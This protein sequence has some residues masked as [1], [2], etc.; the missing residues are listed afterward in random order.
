MHQYWKQNRR[1]ILMTITHL[2]SFHLRAVR[3]ETKVSDLSLDNIFSKLIL[4][5]WISLIEVEYNILISENDYFTKK[6]CNKVNLTKKTLVEKWILLLDYFFREQYFKNQDRALNI[7]TL[8]HTAY[9]RYD[10][11]KRIILNDLNLFVELRNKIAHGQWAVALNCDLLQKNQTL[12][13][14]IW[15]LTK[16]EMM[17]I[18]SLHKNLPPILKLLI[19]TKKIFERDYDKYVNRMIKANN[20]ADLKYNWIKR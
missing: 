5:L 16:K 20:D 3:K 10:T 6:Y 4:V 1:Q 17:L 2:N 7:T 11:L 15:K 14:H 13:T 12:T 9:Y 18:K 19:Q 8:G